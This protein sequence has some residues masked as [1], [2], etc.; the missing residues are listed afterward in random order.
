MAIV[1]QVTGARKGMKDF[2]DFPYTIYRVD[3]NWCPLPRFERKQFFSP[4]NPSM[5]NMEV[6]YFVAYDGERPIGRVTAHTDEGHNRHYKT[7]QGFFGFYEALDEPAV[8]PLLMQAVE[9]W[10]RERRMTSVIGPMNFTT[11]HEL[12]FLTEGFQYP[13]TIL[14]P[15]TKAYY[16]R[17]MADLGYRV[18][19]ELVAYRLDRRTPLPENLPRMVNRLMEKHGGDITIRAIDMT[20]FYEDVETMRRIYNSAWDGNWGF[21]PMEID[22]MNDMAKQLKFFAE[23]PFITLVFKKNRPAAFLLPMPDINEVFFKIPDGRLFPTGFLKL[24]RHKRYIRTG[25]ILLMGVMPE[26]RLQGLE[27]IMFDRLMRD[28]LK[29]NHYDYLETT[30]IL[31]DNYLMCRGMDYLGA[32]LNKRYI[33]VKKELSPLQE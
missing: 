27:L 10:V 20:R 16:P 25:S 18:E 29:Q 7:R 8:A 17:Q 14:M 2:I 13:P 32:Q 9:R 24:L 12:G 30:W 1:K 3:P 11:K 5:A 21:I 4:Q 15:Y 19:K 31:A 6:A 22:E 28:A 33:V 23:L 26:Y